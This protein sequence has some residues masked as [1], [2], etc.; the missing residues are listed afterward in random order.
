VFDPVE[1]RD[2]ERAAYAA[3]K[4]GLLNLTR[5]LAI[6]WASDNIQVNAILPGW[7]DT[8]LTKEARQRIPELDDKVIGRAP[9]QRWGVPEDISGAAVF[10]AGSASNFVTG[11]GLVVDGGYTAAG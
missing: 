5:S 11:T 8:N 1:P 3:S 6:A 9:A 4:G 10:L 2:G 7:I